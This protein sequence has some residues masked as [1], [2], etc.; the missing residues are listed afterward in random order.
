MEL[1]VNM[2][3]GIINP[4]RAWAFPRLQEAVRSSPK[5]LRNLIIKAKIIRQVF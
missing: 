5:I 1:I 2:M 3:H 4:R